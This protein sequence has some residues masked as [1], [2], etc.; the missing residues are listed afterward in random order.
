MPMYD[1]HCHLCYHDSVEFQKMCSADDAPRVECEVCQYPMTRQVS[2]PHTDLKD[3]GKPIEMF[4]IAMND[5]TEVR[6]FKQR[7]PDVECNDDFDHPD[8]GLPVARN[9]KQ[10][11]QALAAAGFVETN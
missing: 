2:L 4:S 10:K 6:A 8:F 1:Y 3:Y 9:R 5:E 11:L 7:C